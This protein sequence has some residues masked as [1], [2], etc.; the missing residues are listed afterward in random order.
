MK[1]QIKKC[2]EYKEEKYLSEFYKEKKGKY[3]VRGKCKKCLNIKA[4]QYDKTHPEIRR[5]ADANYNKNHKLKRAVDKKRYKELHKDVIDA[6]T[7][8]QRFK[9]LNRIQRHKRRALL[10]NVKYERFNPSEIFERDKYRCQICRRKTKPNLNTL[11]HLFPNLDHIISL[12]NGGAHSRINTQCLCRGCNL[13]KNN[14]D[15]NVQLRM[16]G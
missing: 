7:H 10:H 14:R 11:H 6:Y 9:D 4:K 13:S 3:G 15:T 16:F 12:S 1:M 2:S 5:K 8:S